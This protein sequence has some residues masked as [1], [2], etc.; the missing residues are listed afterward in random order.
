MLQA[1]PRS[2]IV[3]WLLYNY[4]TPFKEYSRVEIQHLFDHLRIF[5][6]FRSVIEII[7]LEA[8]NHDKVATILVGIIGATAQHQRSVE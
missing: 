5:W 7:V 8:P 1:N 2:I 3:A 6:P 4:S